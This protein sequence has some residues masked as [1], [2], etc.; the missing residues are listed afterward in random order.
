[1]AVGE[2]M[3]LAAH[4]DSGTPTVIGENLNG[5]QHGPIEPTLRGGIGNRSTKRLRWF[6]G[7][8]DRKC[9]RGWKTIGDL[10]EHHY[11]VRTRPERRATVA[12]NR[13][14]FGRSDR[15]RAV[16]GLPPI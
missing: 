5:C 14:G 15:L 1:M 6:V 3:A 13:E 12:V 10:I 16:I 7:V 2:D 4:E 8:M 9:I 11:V